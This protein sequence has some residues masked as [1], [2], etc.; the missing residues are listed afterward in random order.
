[1]YRIV[2]SAIIQRPVA[3]VFDIAADPHKQ[4]A[5][6]TA[7]LR[8]VEKLTPGPLGRGARYRGDFKGFGPVEYEFVEY[9]PGRR[10]AHRA[11]MP[12]GEMRHVF[13]FEPIP[14]GTRMTQE[15]VLTPNFAGRLLWPVMMKRMLS[16]RFREIASKIRQ[17]L[18]TGSR[19]DTPLPAQP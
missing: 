16:K 3:E 14:E 7:M 8:R 10:F 12:M 13:T 17:H 15:G 6:D 4:L 19:T 5:W 1:M 9:E 11:Q 2:E 18:A